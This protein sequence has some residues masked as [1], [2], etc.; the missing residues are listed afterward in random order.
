MRNLSVFLL[1][2]L[3]ATAIGAPLVKNE[4]TSDLCFAAATKLS[5]SD[6]DGAFAEL[7]PHWPLPAEELKNLAYQTQ[8]QLAMINGRFGTPIGAEFVET[9]VAGES[10][11]QHRY[12]VKYTNH[13]IRFNCTFY[14]P[15]DVWLINAVTWDDQTQKLFD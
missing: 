6:I 11:L 1:A 5:M 2:T 7:Q 4:Q 12:I 9:E 14:K 3:S 13:A 15:K 8:S 10:F